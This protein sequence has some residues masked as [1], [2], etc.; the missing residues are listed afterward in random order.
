MVYSREV[1]DT[2]LTFAASGWT[3][4]E[5]DRESTFVL[6]DKETQSLWFPMAEA[7]CCVLTGIAGAYAD[8]RAQGIMNMERIN[9]PDWA[10]RF[11]ETKFVYKTFP[12]VDP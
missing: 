10:A 12:N 4:G 11:P 9:W 5:I 2:I 8:V 7:D 1:N 6:A 3:Y